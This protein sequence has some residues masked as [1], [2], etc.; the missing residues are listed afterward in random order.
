MKIIR[1][2]GIG[3]V[4]HVR[5][6][7]LSVGILSP[8]AQDIQLEGA[9]QAGTYLDMMMRAQIMPPLFESE[10]L[11]VMRQHTTHQILTY[12]TIGQDEFESVFDT[13]DIIVEPEPFEIFTVEDV[14]DG[15]I[16]SWTANNG[17]FLQGNF[18]KKTLTELRAE[19]PEYAVTYES[20]WYTHANSF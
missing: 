17:R 2:L 20:Y 12:D 15:I 8:I 11:H 1:K 6:Q 18:A 10:L 3:D 4:Q 9:C 5:T 13:L 16:E 14:R 19:F 7:L